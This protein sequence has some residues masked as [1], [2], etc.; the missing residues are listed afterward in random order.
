MMIVAF[1]HRPEAVPGSGTLAHDGFSVFD[2]RETEKLKS[3]KISS[4][5]TTSTCD[6]FDRNLIPFSPVTFEA[7]QVLDF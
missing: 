5:A 2:F 4:A 7:G 1:P 6:G 3:L